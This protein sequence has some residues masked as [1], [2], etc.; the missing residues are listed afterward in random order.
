[1]SVS[2][3]QIKELRDATGVSMM[4][5]K[6]ALEEAGGDFEAAIDV[7]RK[8][9][10]AKAVDRASRETGQGAVFIASEGGKSAMIKLA[11]E[12]DFV[13]RGDDFVELGALLLSKVMSG[14]LTSPE[15]EIPEIKDAGLKFGEN[16]QVSGVVVY[17]SGVSGGY[18]H[19][20]KKIGVLV[21]LDGGNEE[22]AKDISM[23]VA[24]TAP[25]FLSPEEVSEELVTREKSV[26]IDQLKAEGKPE[27]I[28]EKI[29]MGKE[30]K[31][32]EEN[33]LLKQAF[34][35]NPDVTIEQLLADSGAKI[36]G[37]T[38]FSI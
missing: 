20:N 15:T 19:S 11:C 21:N 37:F 2:I 34:V 31:Y 25:D 9:G 12:T 35:K 14:E 22:L 7:L 17:D 26:W 38:R 13:A 4:A 6:T 36:N 24:A 28:M 5:C 23:H 16:L 29:M 33:A 8:K 32:R 27:E 18:I 3:E 30:K 1:M 10:E